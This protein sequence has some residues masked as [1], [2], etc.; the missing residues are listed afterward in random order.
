M[1]AQIKNRW[2]ANRLEQVAA[3]YGVP[4]DCLRLLGDFDSLVYA[5]EAAGRPRI[6]R[7]SHSSVRSAALVLGELDWIGHL[8][9]GGASV[10]PAVL[11]AS[12]HLIQEI[13]DG[14]GGAFIAAAF[15][16]A[17]GASPRAGDWTPAATERYGALL[18][19]IHRLSQSYA[20][21]DPAWRRL[22]W[23]DPVMLDVGRVLPAGDERVLAEFHQLLAD[24][25][26]LPRTGPGY[27]LIHQDAHG[28]NLTIDDA[29]RI[30]LFD[31]Y[32]CTYSWFVND[33]AIVLFYAAMW[34]KDRAA[35]AAAF[36]PA[37]L[38]GYWRENDLNGRW[39]AQIPRFLRLREI[40]LYAVILRE[41]GADWHGNAWNAG[42]MRGR[43]ERIEANVP[44]IDYDFTR[45]A[46]PV[47]R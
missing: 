11:A 19:R 36:M 37:F 33:I 47:T 27:G 3:C 8:V 5:Y 38:A 24:L 21:A 22:H 15:E 35:F 2:T 7:V 6:L 17:P 10:S 20:P 43:K 23:D 34:A 44:Y 25:D 12:G 9:R 1:N 39:L 41:F 40:D 32:D 30:T 4:A 16:R 46:R 13:D 45:L 18:G 14:R 31:C 28:E 29:G 26:E 42:Y